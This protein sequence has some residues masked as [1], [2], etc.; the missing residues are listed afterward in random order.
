MTPAEIDV[1]LSA[2]GQVDSNL[3]RRHEGTGLGLPIC[4]S[5]TELHGGEMIVESAPNVGTTLAVHFP[6]ARTVQMKAKAS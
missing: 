6:A 5:L 2:F 3:A 1:A 4:R